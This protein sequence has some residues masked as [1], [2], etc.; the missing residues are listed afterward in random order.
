MRFAVKRAVLPNRSRLGW[1]QLANMA[2][3]APKTDTL[4]A[5]VI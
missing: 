5:I 4:E 1:E 3:Q 2:K